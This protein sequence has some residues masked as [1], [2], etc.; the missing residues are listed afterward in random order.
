[1]FTSRDIADYYNQTLVHYQN[2]WHLD[3]NLAVHYGI[4]DE[5]TRN[6]QESLTNT[7]KVLMEMASIKDGEQILD[8]GCGVGGSA[9]FLA[10][11]RKAKV[12]GITLSEKQYDYATKKCRE[13]GYDNL[14]N[15][16][17]EDY[18][19]TGFNHN[20]FDVIWAIESIT[21]SQNKNQFAREAYRI[22]KPGG[23]LIIAD[24]FKSKEEQKD[25]DNLLEKWRK[26]WSMA[27]FLCLPEYKNIF[28][29]SGFKL[30]NEKEVTIEITPTVK[31]MYYSYLLGG[32]WA[33]IY[34]LFYKPSLYAKNHYKSGLY[35]YKALRQ[36][37][38]N[39]RILLF[40]KV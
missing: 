18:N 3:C 31:R 19:Q 7:N 5:N 38:W 20:N 14:V 40:E 26:L 21:S 17:I 34:N 12:S 2:W 22:L 13:L 35:Q 25:T 9:F 39:Y 24:Y 23:R 32:P 30:S 27:P 8:A 6:F 33:V 1:M 4:W 28:Q 11:H 10:K 36:G 37:L 15:F 16:K 29:Q